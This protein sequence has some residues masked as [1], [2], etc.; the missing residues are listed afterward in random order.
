MPDTLHV[1]VVSLLWD[2]ESALIST[3]AGPYRLSLDSLDLQSFFPSDTGHDFWMVS[4]SCDSPYVL[5]VFK[6]SVR[7]DTSFGL[8]NIEN[9]NLS[10]HEKRAGER[11]LQF[12]HLDTLVVFSDTLKNPPAPY[13]RTIGSLDPI[14]ILP[15][16]VTLH[17]V[18]SPGGYYSYQRLDSNTDGES[19]YK[20]KGLRRSVT[21]TINEPW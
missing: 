16:N 9:A 6:D 5:C 1:S 14:S 12:F 4:F 8:Y 19:G 17:D 18:I 2:Q 13:L 3:L 15:A 11:T 21:L 20:V 10:F 7:A